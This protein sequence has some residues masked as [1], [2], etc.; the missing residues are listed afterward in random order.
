MSPYDDIVAKS[1]FGDKQESQRSLTFANVAV[2]RHRLL[3][4]RRCGKLALAA[5]DESMRDPHLRATDLGALLRV[6][7]LLGCDNIADRMPEEEWSVSIR[8]GAVVLAWAM[9]KSSE[10]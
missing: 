4:C 7:R 10:T 2:R 9:R 8:A 1:A 3:G 6:A 5:T